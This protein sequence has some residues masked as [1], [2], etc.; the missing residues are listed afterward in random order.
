MG[1]HVPKPR[2]VPCSCSLSCDK[3][4]IF[5]TFWKHFSSAMRDSLHC[6]NELKRDRTRGQPQFTAVTQK[7]H[8]THHSSPL[9]VRLLVGVF[10]G[11]GET[12]GQWHFCFFLKSSSRWASNSADKNAFA[13]AHPQSCRKPGHECDCWREVWVCGCCFTSHCFWLQ[14]CSGK[15]CPARRHGHSIVPQH[16]CFLPFQLSCH[17]CLQGDPQGLKERNQPFFGGKEVAGRSNLS[18]FSPCLKMAVQGLL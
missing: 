17:K 11:K 14:S 3:C 4:G 12:K 15:C 6:T 5:P 1:N 13:L 8:L 7:K 2:P 9:S 16:C 18:F 10:V